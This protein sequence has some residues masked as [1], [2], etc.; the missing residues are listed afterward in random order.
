MNVHNSECIK[1]LEPLQTDKSS[2]RQ[3]WT[4]V[5]SLTTWVFLVI[6]TSQPVN[7]I[8]I[9]MMILLL[10]FWFW[11]LQG[12]WMPNLYATRQ[13]F[14][15]QNSICS[16]FSFS[17]SNYDLCVCFIPANLTSLNTVFYCLSST[18]LAIFHCLL[19]NCAK[20]VVA[21]TAEIRLNRQFVKL[22]RNLVI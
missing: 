16:W 14:S 11:V 1:F 17:F 2:R 4:N 18:L 8:I 10:A 9:S 15:K 20:V 5:P 7:N 22:N 6:R 13:R 21:P 19:N 3:N 12:Q